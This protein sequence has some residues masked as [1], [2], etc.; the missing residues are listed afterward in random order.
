[1]I[2]KGLIPLSINTKTEKIHSDKIKKNII[3]I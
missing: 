2:E 1:M 3:L